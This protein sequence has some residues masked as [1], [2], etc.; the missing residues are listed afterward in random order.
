MAM[1]GANGTR[2]IDIMDDMRSIAQSSA[3][4]K[5]RE[6]RK[7]SLE[8]LEKP[9]ILLPASPVAHTH[10]RRTLALRVGCDS[11]ALHEASHC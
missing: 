8:A 10:K 3:I 1:I 9:A 11:I 4:S 2:M 7:N 5:A 6:C